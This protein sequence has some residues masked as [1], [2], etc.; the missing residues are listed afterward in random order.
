MNRAAFTLV[1]IVMVIV[2]LGILASLALPRLDRDVKQE[3]ADSILSDIRYTQHL[4]L[5]DNKHKFNKS[6]WQRAFWKFNIES[7]AND[8][9]LFIGIGTDLDY[10][11]EPSMEES[12]LDPIN[13]KYMFWKNTSECSEGLEELAISSRIFLTNKY[14]IVSVEGTGGCA[15][16]QHIGFDNTGRP[17]VSFSNSDQPNYAS[18]MSDTCT[19]TFTMIDDSIFAIDI[20]PETGYAYIVGQENS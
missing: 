4:A 16:V 11:N 19:F 9:G 8:S 12:A 1:E 3:A 2:V 17:H 14:S 6:Q 13:G 18:V 20:L 5:T 10:S 7:C 15:G